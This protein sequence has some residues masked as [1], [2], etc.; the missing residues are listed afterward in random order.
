[1]PA[2]FDF[3]FR[4]FE[5]QEVLRLCGIRHFF[6]DSLVLRVELCGHVDVVVAKREELALHPVD[7]LEWVKVQSVHVVD[8]PETDVLP[9]LRSQQDRSEHKGL[10]VDIS[11]L[12]ACLFH[13]RFEVDKADDDALSG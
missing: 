3:H 9:K 6:D 12:D 1:M 13:Y 5:S 10:P 8:V 2:E 4:V 11:N 7:R